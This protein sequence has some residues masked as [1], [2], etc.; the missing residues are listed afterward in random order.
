MLGRLLAQQFEKQGLQYEESSG[1]LW[2]SLCTSSEG[3]VVIEKATKEDVLEHCKLKRHMIAMEKEIAIEQ[4]C[5][6]EIN[7]R[8]MLLDHHCIYPAR[9]FGKGT[10][11]LDETLGYIIAED[12]CGGVKLIPRH[13]YTVVELIIPSSMA[14]LPYEPDY[15]VERSIRSKKRRAGVKVWIEQH[16]VSIQGETAAIKRKRMLFQETVV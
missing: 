10:V 5:P 1:I 13:K 3:L 14:P 6:V 11:I 2:C 15:F 12:V 9:M 8:Q 16:N 4:Y 7:G